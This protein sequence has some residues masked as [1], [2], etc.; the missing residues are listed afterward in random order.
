MSF[1]QIKEFKRLRRQLAL[2]RKLV[3]HNC[4]SFSFL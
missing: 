4:Y 1:V 2:R 3:L